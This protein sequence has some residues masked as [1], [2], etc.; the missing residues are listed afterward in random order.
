MAGS[1]EIRSAGLGRR[2][3][4]RR[5]G[6]G[7]KGG[8]VGKLP[9]NQPTRQSSCGIPS[10]RGLLRRQ[11]VV[12]APRMEGNDWV[13]LSDEELLE[14]R[15]SQLGLMLEDSEAQPLIQQLYAEL[16]AKGL[17]FYPPCHVGDEWFVPVGIPAIF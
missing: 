6:S 2:G 1:D 10:G 17:T 7:G 14:K 11:R 13:G 12:Y 5:R 8:R 3:E 4:G 15:I 9:S 16:S